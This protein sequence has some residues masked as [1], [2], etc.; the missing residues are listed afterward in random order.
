[1][2]NNASP[3]VLR[4]Y[5]RLSTL[6]KV[7]HQNQ[8]VLDIN[9][10][11]VLMD[12]F[13]KK[14]N[15]SLLFIAALP[16]ELQGV[17]RNLLSRRRSISGP[18]LSLPNNFE[19][20]TALRRFRDWLAQ[21][22]Q[23]YLIKWIKA[24]INNISD[25]QVIE[26][27][28]I[29]AASPYLRLS[30][31]P[32]NDIDNDIVFLLVRAGFFA[33]A[34]S[35]LKN[36]PGLW[37]SIENFSG[38]TTTAN[39]LYVVC[40]C[41][42]L[43]KQSI[44][45]VEY[46]LTKPFGIN[47]LEAAADIAKNNL[48]CE[49]YEVDNKPVSM[50]RTKLVEL[51]EKQ[52][53][54]LESK[55]KQAKNKDGENIKY[56]VI[57]KKLHIDGIDTPQDT[58][59]FAENNKFAW[60]E[61]LEI[62]CGTFKYLYKLGR[63]VSIRPELDAEFEDQEIL[64]D[65]FD[66]I[67]KYGDKLKLSY[68]EEIGY[69]LAVNNDEIIEEE[70]TV[71]I[72]SGIYTRSKGGPARYSFDYPWDSST[73]RLHFIHGEKLGGFGRFLTHAPPS[74]DLQNAAI[75]QAIKERAATALQCKDTLFTFQTNEG[76]ITVRVLRFIANKSLKA[77]APLTIDYGFYYWVNEPFWLI[78]K[79][80][81]KPLMQVRYEAFGNDY[82]IVMNSLTYEEDGVTWN[83]G[84]CSEMDDFLAPINTQEYLFDSFDSSEDNNCATS[85]ECQ[86][87]QIT[88]HYDHPGGQNSNRCMP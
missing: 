19:T 20:F 48:P 21:K 68:R 15:N 56:G 71:T 75:P 54:E 29:L 17:G 49:K 63:L 31:I 35:L 74:L 81:G 83:F 52:K 47:E 43:N 62:S 26:K 77:N 5:E 8:Y 32:S 40:N 18:Y 46:L 9:N 58:R 70:D 67:D 86:D 41:A 7:K 37:G 76:P 1:M 16:P 23:N 66:N 57:P 84:T 51:I 14:N 73:Q 10:L 55:I 44:P 28:S 30:C 69:Y 4:R 79:D 38:R 39:L 2:G 64:E 34:L 24:Q 25:E 82:R 61:G 33:A 65:Y 60:L 72:Y 50:I 87:D 53:L 6:A 88:W 78:D 27:D 22:L 80:T 59:E 45:L 36:C 3:W 12:A 85:K 42:K 13:L 11:L